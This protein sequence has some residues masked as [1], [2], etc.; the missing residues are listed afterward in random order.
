MVTL[1]HTFPTSSVIQSGFKGTTRV[2]R[3]GG[4]QS[5]VSHSLTHVCVGEAVCVS[6]CVG[7][8]GA[9]ARRSPPHLCG[10]PTH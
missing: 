2:E 9:A 7:M 8:A 5:V 6:E 1:T 4:Q 3:E 10:G